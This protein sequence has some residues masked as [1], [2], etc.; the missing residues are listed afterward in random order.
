VTLKPQ[1]HQKTK[2][3]KMRGKVNYGRAEYISTAESNKLQAEFGMAPA[4]EGRECR[5]A[6]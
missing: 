4:A 2:N 3:K 1:Y 6:Q 5:C